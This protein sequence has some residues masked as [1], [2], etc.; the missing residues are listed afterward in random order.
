M[1][2]NES[3]SEIALIGNEARVGI[4]ILMGGESMPS[5]TK[6]QSEGNAY[7]LHGLHMK[8]EF[9]LGGELQYFSLLYAQV[10]ISYIAGFSTT[11][12]H[13]GLR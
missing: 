5:D 9:S 6:V 8:R 2:K 1:L 12:V 3:S 11:L 10:T 7:Q 13:P 4:S